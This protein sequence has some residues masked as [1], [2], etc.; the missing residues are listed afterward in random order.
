MN[1]ERSTSTLDA[2]PLP[3][4][5][6]TLHA[7]IRE[8]LDA[9]KKAQHECHGVQQRLDLLLRKLYGP[10]AERFHPEQPWLLPEMAADAATASS[11]SP[12]EECPRTDPT[13]HAPRQRHGGGRKKLPESL[14]RIRIEHTLAE[15]ERICPCCK[16]V[17]VKFGEDFS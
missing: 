4:D 9:L 10:K 13:N 14:S 16:E 1:T 6:P 17:C 3:D 12:S 8:L 15:A 11:A 7:M 5:V 2:T